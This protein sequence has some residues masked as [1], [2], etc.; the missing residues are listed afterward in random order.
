MPLPKI[1]KPRMCAGVDDV[2]DDQLNYVKSLCMIKTVYRHKKAMQF[3]N[4][5][6]MRLYNADAF[7]DYQYV[8]DFAYSR[9]HS[10]KQN[11]FALL[12]GIK[13]KKCNVLYRWKNYF[14]TTYVDCRRASGW[15]FCEWNNTSIFF[16][17][18][19]KKFLNQD[20]SLLSIVVYQI[21]L[22]EPMKKSSMILW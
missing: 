4:N 5:N 18:E 9:F 22:Q 7:F 17:T 15:F 16:R 21:L 10:S 12:D 2:Y 13:G 8:I 6:K 1:K 3:C 19:L 14:D 11:H 20:I